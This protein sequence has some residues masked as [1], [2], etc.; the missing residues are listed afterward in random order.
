MENRLLRALRGESLTPPPIWLM[1]QAGR[2]LPEYREVRAKAGD[3]LSLCYTPTAA[4]EVTL[5][6]IRRFGF[7]AAIVFADILLV[8][9]ALGIGLRFEEGEGP[10]LDPVRDRA[11]LARLGEAAGAAAKLAPVYETLAL[12]RAKLPRE[13]SLIGFAGAPWT[14]ATYVVEGGGSSDQAAAKL[15]AYRDAE[16]FAQLIDRLTEATI[17]YLIRQIEAGA[18]VV[19]IFESWASGLPEAMFERL[20]IAPTARIVAALKTRHPT[21]PVIGFPRGC[22]ALAARYAAET[23]IDALGLDTSQPIGWM[24]TQLKR[25]VALQGNLDPLAL[26]AGGAALERGV[27]DILDAARGTPFVFNLGHGIIPQTDPAHVQRL[28]ELVRG[29]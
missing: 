2:Y 18:D 16:G 14:V 29:A 24:R 22:G 5:Q 9:H 27:A 15:W 11:G 8:P 20:C 25:P 26:A 3:F 17:V 10:K 13:V 7:D 12:V 23:G 19:Q 21:V 4:A 28:V 1:R 6:P